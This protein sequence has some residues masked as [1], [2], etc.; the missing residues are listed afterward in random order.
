M[1]LRGKL[2]GADRIRGTLRA[3]PDGMAHAAAEAAAGALR[4][5]IARHSG[6]AGLQVA[7]EGLRRRVGSD[8][9][10]LAAREFGTLEQ[11]PSPWLAPSLPPALEPMRAA[12]KLA[13]ARAVS[14]FRLRK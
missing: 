2:L 10:G 13:V 3:L 6:I 8:D 4:E 5:E 9:A 12:A 14:T 7:A 11:T 1:K